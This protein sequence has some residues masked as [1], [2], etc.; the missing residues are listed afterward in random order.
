MVEIWAVEM[1]GDGW[2][3]QSMTGR[4]GTLGNLMAIVGKLGWLTLVNGET[5]QRQ[6]NSNMYAKGNN[7]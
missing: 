2:M 3:V 6:Q 5:I 7:V 1:G 4:T